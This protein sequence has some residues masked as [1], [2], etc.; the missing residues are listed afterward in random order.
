MKKAVLALL[1]TSSVVTFSKTN[2]ET[3]NGGDDTV[4]TITGMNAKK[5]IDSLREKMKYT[6]SFVT[7]DAGM[8]QYHISSPGLKC[9]TISAGHLE[10]EDRTPER[11]YSC[12]V[13]F[14]SNGAVNL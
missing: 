13:S 6:G 14:G 5:L 12:E 3:V 9:T 10:P 2:V 4:V 1:I 11:L 7:A 8:G